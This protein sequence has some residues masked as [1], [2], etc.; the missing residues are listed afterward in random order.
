MDEK[1]EVTGSERWLMRILLSDFK[2]ATENARGNR[3]GWTHGDTQNAL[4]AASSLL[5]KLG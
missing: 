3:R 1:I 4:A 5:A 2:T